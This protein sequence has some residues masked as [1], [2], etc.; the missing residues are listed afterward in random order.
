[1]E[2]RPAGQ[3]RKLLGW[4]IRLAPLGTVG[5]IGN[6]V[7]QYGWETLS[8]LGLFAGALYAG[9]AL[10]MGVVYP[11]LLAAHG[12]SPLRFFAK[13][14]PAIQ[15]AFVS[16]SSAA[17]LP[18]AETAAEDLGVDRAYAS[19][20]VPIASTTKMDGCAAVYPAVAAIFVAQ[21]YGIVLSPLDYGLIVAVSVL[22]SATA[23]VTGA[24][25]MLTLT[26]S[27]L[28]LPLEGV[29]LLLAIDPILD[30]G[31]TAVNVTGQ[32]LIPTI[33]ARRE[34]LLDQARYDGVAG[35]EP[36]LIA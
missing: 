31:R 34:G 17:A 23:G 4:V 20:A 14:W 15:L 2:R 3:L 5:L 7:V 12:L 6:A 30:M 22:G 18:L 19:F 35:E 16:R 10:V 8:R 29:G 28:G 24:V 9:L 25:V 33:V 36:G 32:I 27:T 11:A 21:F 1:V 13:A 26:L